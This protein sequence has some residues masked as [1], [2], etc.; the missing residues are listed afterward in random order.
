MSDPICKWMFACL[1]NTD[2]FDPLARENRSRIVEKEVVKGFPVWAFQNF[3]TDSNE[4]LPISK[5]RFN[6]ASVSLL[7]NPLC[8]LTFCPSNLDIS[9]LIVSL[10]TIMAVF[11][12][13]TASTV[14]RGVSSG[15]H[16]LL[17]NRSY[18]SSLSRTV[19]RETPSHLAMLDWLPWENSTAWR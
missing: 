18:L 1:F 10:W 5:P 7:L 4:T 6:R 9:L 19:M 3:L 14:T 16:F 11:E 2:F 15:F 8:F 12:L 13:S 17:G